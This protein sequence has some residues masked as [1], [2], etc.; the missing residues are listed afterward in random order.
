MSDGVIKQPIYT[1]TDGLGAK[2]RKPNWEEQT[3]MAELSKITPFY[4]RNYEGRQDSW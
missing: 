4:R 1:W 3:Y 2:K